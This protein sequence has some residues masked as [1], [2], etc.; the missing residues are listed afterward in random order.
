MIWRQFIYDKIE[1]H[2]QIL[3]K[4]MQDFNNAIVARY[5]LYY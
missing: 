1:S 2:N 5:W 3:A 4:S